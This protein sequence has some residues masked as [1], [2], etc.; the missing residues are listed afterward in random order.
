[1]VGNTPDMA[2]I[3]EIEPIFPSAVNRARIKDA[4]DQAFVYPE[5]G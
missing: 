4:G 5:S 2:K 1:M 3:R